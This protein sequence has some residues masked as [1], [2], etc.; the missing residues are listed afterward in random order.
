MHKSTIIGDEFAKIDRRGLNMA[1]KGKKE[2]EEVVE[3]LKSTKKS[4]M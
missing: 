4:W 3:E 2:V 1:K